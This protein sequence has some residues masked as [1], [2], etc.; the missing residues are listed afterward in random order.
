MKKYLAQNNIEG[1]I[2]YQKYQ[3]L[4]KINGRL[5]V[6]EIDSYHKLM[7]MINISNK[8]VI[9]RY[10]IGF[11]IKKFKDRLGEIKFIYTHLETRFKK[12]N[13]NRFVFDDRYFGS[14]LIY[15]IKINCSHKLIN[16]LLQKGANPIF[17]SKGLKWNS[18]KMCI[19]KKN[20]DAIKC[21]FDNKIMIN[22]IIYLIDNTLQLNVSQKEKMIKIL[23]SQNRKIIYG[24]CCS[25]FC[26]A[27]KYNIKEMFDYL[28]KEK[29]N[30]DLMQDNSD[31]L[32]FN[33]DF[34][35]INKYSLQDMVN[36]A[37]PNCDTHILDRIFSQKRMMRDF[38]KKCIQYKI[39]LSNYFDSV[40]LIG[41]IK[42]INNLKE[43]NDLVDLFDQN[44]CL[45]V[46]LNL[47]FSKLTFKEL[48]INLSDKLIR[49]I[50]LKYLKHKI[51]NTNEVIEME[52]IDKL[53]SEFMI[54]WNG[55][56]W[57]FSNY[58]NYIINIAKGINKYDSKLPE[59]GGMKIWQ[60]FEEIKN[61]CSYFDDNSLINY[62]N[63]SKSIKL[64]DPFHVRSIE[65]ACNMFWARGPIW[66]AEIKRLLSNDL[67]QE[68]I[69]K[70]QHLSTWEMPG[71]MSNKLLDAINAIKQQEL[72]HFGQKFSSFSQIEKKAINSI[73]NGYVTES[74]INS[75][76]LGVE[77]IMVMG[78]KLHRF[79]SRIK[80]YNLD[81]QIEQN[82]SRPRTNSVSTN[83]FIEYK[84]NSMTRQR[85]NSISIVVS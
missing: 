10:W 76:L 40:P 65:R 11:L 58:K 45:N 28:L 59:I 21:F 33:N 68:W 4:F 36:N 37:C 62:L 83:S 42:K 84:K 19:E 85:R 13:L 1:L 52:P 81:L 60:S 16:F 49:E 12:I 74:K 3:K 30:D 27:I 9:E 67:Y 35:E 48:N 50:C 70:K 57:N 24:D 31:L 54:T 43:L 15:A 78:E 46:N 64:I 20:T 73:S 66:D 77:C 7:F 44:P 55:V 80:S 69:K 23:F 2:D 61:L 75:T 8:D 47:N 34:L 26:I 41:L 32:I 38:F 63:I 5:D 53:E 51:I 39:D 29:I 22:E 25:P 14:A 71:N 82:Y 72:L 17:K 79:V 18:L 6:L 56:V